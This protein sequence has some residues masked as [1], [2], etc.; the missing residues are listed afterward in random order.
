MRIAHFSHFSCTEPLSIYPKKTHE[1]W[2]TKLR[3]KGIFCEFDKMTIDDAMKLVVILHTA[4]EKLQR[5]ITVKDTNLKTVIDMRA[6][7][8]T[9]R[10]N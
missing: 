5:N 7:E 3:V 9:Q 2:I 8:L 10:E 4:S 1:E 6:L